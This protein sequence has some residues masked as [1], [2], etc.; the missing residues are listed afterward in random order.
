MEV[1]EEEKDMQTSEVNKANKCECFACTC[2]RIGEKFGVSGM[3]IAMGGG[4]L[5]FEL[6]MGL[7]CLIA[8]FTR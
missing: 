1:S 8:V 2:D 7:L 6:A 3:A 4:L 5:I